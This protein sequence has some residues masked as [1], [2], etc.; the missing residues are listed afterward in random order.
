MTIAERIQVL[1]ETL[2]ASG[3]AD[4][5]ITV[6][7]TRANLRRHFKPEKRGGQLRVG[8]HQLVLVP[9][10]RPAKLVNLDWV[11]DTP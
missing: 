10:A 4:A 6:I 1:A 2:D 11:T 8:Q 3:K 9:R 7:G 5:P